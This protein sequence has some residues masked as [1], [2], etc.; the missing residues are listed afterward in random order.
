MLEEWRP[1]PGYSGLY[2][3]SNLGRIRSLDRTVIYRPRGWIKTKTALKKGKVLSP[4]VDKDG[5]L[6]FRLSGENGEQRKFGAHQ[7]VALTFIPNPY[8]FPEVAHIDHDRK[9][10]RSDNLKWATRGGN[11]SDSVIE[12]RYSRAGPNIG[13]KRTFTADEVRQIRARFAAGERQSDIAKSLGIRQEQV[14][15]LVMRERW[16]H[17]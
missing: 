17:L 14:R 5:Y 10:N 12:N 1:M 6:R 16:S 3:V 2:E 13:T 8:G 11:H 4:E 7:A 9:N 15:K